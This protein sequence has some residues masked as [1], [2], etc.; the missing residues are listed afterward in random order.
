MSFRTLQSQT[1][2]KGGSLT[3]VKMSKFVSPLAFSGNSP[4][5][6][7]A[8][9]VSTRLVLLHGRENCQL[10][11]LWNW[12]NVVAAT[13]FCHFW[14]IL[15]VFLCPLTYS[16]INILWA[17]IRRIVS[18]NLSISNSVYVSSSIIYVI[19]SPPW[20]MYIVIQVTVSC[21]RLRGHVLQPPIMDRWI[22]PKMSIL[23]HTRIHNKVQCTCTNSHVSTGICHIIN[24][25]RKA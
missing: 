24:P 9:M 16:H 10:P 11:S 19:T 8:Q 12:N 4:Y 20:Y 7:F 15:N 14:W 1:T 18:R 13:R 21:D 3:L 23:V 5:H 25:R 2:W 17:S 22:E 6:S